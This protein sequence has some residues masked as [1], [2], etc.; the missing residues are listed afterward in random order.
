MR[1]EALRFAAVGVLNSAV[2]I[3]VIFMGLALLGMSDAT[4]NLF[5]YA[6]GWIISYALNK[7][8]TFHHR[9]ATTRSFGRFIAVSAGVYLAN[10]GV[11]LLLHRRIGANVYFAELAG[12]A[13]YTTLGFL[14][15][16]YYAFTR[17]KQRQARKLSP[18]REDLERSRHE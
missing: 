11:V 10:L 18:A 13:I 12:V 5:G 15:S 16:Y 2:G 8:W 6:V 4:A 14:G 1:K 3:G 7:T 9:G 17:T